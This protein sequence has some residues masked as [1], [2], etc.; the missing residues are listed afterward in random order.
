MLRLFCCYI[1]SNRVPY[2]ESWSQT[3][4]VARLIHNSWCFCFE[5]SKCLYYRHWPPWLGESVWFLKIKQQFVFV[6]CFLF[7]VLA[8]IFALQC[9]IFW[10]LQNS[11]YNQHMFK[12]FSIHLFHFISYALF[13][14]DWLQKSF[15]VYICIFRNNNTWYEYGYPTFFW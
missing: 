9:R 11:V 13:S 14:T 5:F 7:L 1:V 3:G 12:I 2:S 8:C 15:V 10:R 6:S 4:F